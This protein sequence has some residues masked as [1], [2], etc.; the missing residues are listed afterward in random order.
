[1]CEVVLSTCLPRPVSQTM[2]VYHFQPLVQLHW[3][4]CMYGCDDIKVGKLVFLSLDV[5]V[6]I[7]ERV[8]K[9]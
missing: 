6:I 4:Y 5:L 3:L 7:G 9:A 2:E 1:M 8:N